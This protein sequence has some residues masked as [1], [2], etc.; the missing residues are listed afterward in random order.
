M[1]A[2]G[3]IDRLL[4]W[5]GEIGTEG[6]E[7]LLALRRGVGIEGPDC[8]R[9]AG[10]EIFL[11]EGTRLMAVIN[12]TP[13]SFWAGSRS[14]TADEIGRA[15]DRAAGEGAD[16]IDIG[17]EST[18]PGAAQVSAGEEIERVAGAIEEAV[19]R[20]GLP[21]SIDTASAEVAEAALDVG[22]VIV[23]DISAGLEDPAIFSLTAAREAGLVLMH[24]QGASATMQDDP[25][26]DD[27]MG[28]IHT[29]LADR[30]GAA[31]TAGVAPD[32]IAIDPG[33]GFGKRRLHNFEIYRRMA[34]FHS[35]GYPLLAGPSRKRHTSGPMDRPPEERL[36]G[37]ASACTVLAWQGAQIIRV[38]DVAEMKHALDTLDEIRGAVVED[39][40][41]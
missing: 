17:G 35:F 21:V 1:I 8:W 22:A 19:R 31:V 2:C 27:L 41:S 12:V 38:H 3:R 13:D 36:M 20:T 10:G 40:V 6:E 11:G 24:R 29:F 28:E 7:I 15:L 37:T 23:N 4:D 5:L 25:H 16:L 39:R 9:F 26:Y 14:E 33:L 34:E 32:R 18:R 30:A